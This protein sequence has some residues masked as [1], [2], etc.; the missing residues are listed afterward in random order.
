M[1]TETRKRPL[2]RGLWGT[3]I[4]TAVLAYFIAVQVFDSKVAFGIFIAIIS[5]L[6]VN[7]LVGS[8]TEY[9]TSNA[10]PPTQHI[11]DA[12]QTG[13]ATN[14]IAG[15]ATGLRSTALPMVVFAIAIYVAFHFAGIYGI[16][17]AAM[18]MLCTAGMVCS[19]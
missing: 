4:I 7:V 8:I 9:Y 5:G 19:S 6:V 14:I 16:A 17:M 13:A 10:K 15:I 12:S 18:G 1:R 3:N 2:N 11:A